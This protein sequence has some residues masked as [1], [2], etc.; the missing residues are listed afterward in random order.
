VY[1]GFKQFEP[2]ASIISQL[3]GDRVE[4]TPE[5]QTLVEQTVKEIKK[6]KAAEKRAM[7]LNCDELSLQLNDS[8][9]CCCVG[10]VPSRASSSP[11][12]HN[13]SSTL[14]ST[15]SFVVI[16][17]IV[18]ASRLSPILITCFFL[19]A[20]ESFGHPPTHW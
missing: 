11:S 6:S 18:T 12:P 16:D 2:N 8:S 7:Q 4:V 19:V 14:L 1:T 17:R 9:V 10:V 20:D 3:N 5:L 13:R 15:H